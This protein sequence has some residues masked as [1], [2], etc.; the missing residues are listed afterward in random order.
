MD[1]VGSVEQVT[2]ADPPVY[3]DGLLDCPTTSA[4]EYTGTRAAPGSWSPAERS[5]VWSR[6]L[7][8]WR[9]PDAQGA[10]CADC[11]GFD[12][13]DL[14]AHAFSDADLERRGQDHIPPSDVAAIVDFVHEHR[15]R[16]SIKRPCTLESRTFQPGGQV[17]AGDTAVKRE[18]A[19]G[20][21]LEDMGFLVLTHDS[22]D[23]V[24]TAVQVYQQLMDADVRSIPIPMPLPRWSDDHTR[25]E[26]Y[27]NLNDWITDEGVI[28]QSSQRERWYG[29]HDAYLE[30]PSEENLFA[31]LE[32]ISDTMVPMPRNKH[33]VINRLLDMLNDQRYLAAILA[34]HFFRM[35][36]V[37]GRGWHNSGAV[38][39]DLAYTYRHKSPGDHSQLGDIKPFGALIGV[40]G[41][42]TTDCRDSDHTCLLPIPQGMIDELSPLDSLSHERALGSFSPTWG[43]LDWLWDASMM[44]S[45]RHSGNMKYWRSEMRVRDY[46]LLL[47]WM[48]VTSFALKMNLLP[49][50]RGPIRPSPEGLD[51]TPRIIDGRW[52]RHFL[53]PENNKKFN[54]GNEAELG[55]RNEYVLRMARNFHVATLLIME[56]LLRE[57]GTVNDPQTL[58]SEMGD[59]AD[60][61]LEYPMSDSERARIRTLEDQVEALV[62]DAPSTDL[63]TVY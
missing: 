53:V 5:E 27:R 9:R 12:G 19:F 8:A 47:T 18:L 17:V 50:T 55:P 14:A 21:Q 26:E 34:Q 36:L 1:A 44:S 54:R 58:L 49:T 59:A 11:H 62:R 57:G 61:I 3:G 51:P 25:G 2:T 13:L 56:S 15:L 37:D 10:A 33:K 24:E 20:K 45:A 32:L 43:V 29:M 30:D 28:P 7:E 22:I 4:P 46:H 40:S 63:I 39:F 35:A 38:V 31:I 16:Y 41:L 48:R 42:A 60:V 23:D 6:G 52:W